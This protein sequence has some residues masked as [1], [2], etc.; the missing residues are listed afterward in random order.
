MANKKRLSQVIH[1]VLKCSVNV[2]S[3]FD[4][5]AK[6]FHEYKRQLL[7]ALQIVHHYIRLKE[8]RI[9]PPSP[10]TYI[11]AGKAAAGYYMAKLTIQFIHSIAQIISNDPLASDWINVVFLPDYC[12]S[13]AETIIPAADLSEQISTS[14]WEASGTGVMKFAMNGALTM[15]SQDGANLEILREV[16]EKNIYLFGL[17]P[18]QASALASNWEYHPRNFYRSS[19]SIQRVMDAVAEGQFDT[20]ARGAFRPLIASILDARDPYFC[21][22]DFDSYISVHDA[23]CAD[24]AEASD[25]TRKAI[26]NVA[27]MGQFSS[28]RT[29]REYAEKIWNIFPSPP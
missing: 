12:V 9:E 15:G 3:L 25:W 1:K 20:D 10:V 27:G 19:S 7:N 13:L 17:S 6:R 8:D 2:Q 28:D 5:H 23:A 16:G 18:A 14:G 4:V 24:F 21:L 22:A 11:F 29:I 26:M